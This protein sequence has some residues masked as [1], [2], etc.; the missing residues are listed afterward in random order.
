MDDLSK[1]PPIEKAKRRI[2]S[3]LSGRKPEV[4]SDLKRVVSVRDL[5]QRT[6]VRSAFVVLVDLLRQRDQDKLVRKWIERI[7]D[8]KRSRKTTREAVLLVS[9]FFP[10]SNKSTI[11]RYADTLESALASKLSGAALYEWLSKRRTAS[12]ATGKNNIESTVEMLQTEGHKI[13][14]EAEFNELG[15]SSGDWFLAVGRVSKSSKNKMYI[16]RA[17]KLKGSPQRTLGKLLKKAGQK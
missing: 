11:S 17:K 8:R 2:N 15:I 3:L 10:S 5:T 13:Q 12:P 4:P 7:T 1:H 14:F 16:Y 9:Y 6:R